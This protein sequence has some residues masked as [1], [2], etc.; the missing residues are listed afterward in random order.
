MAKKTTE[1]EPCAEVRCPIYEMM[2]YL[3]GKDT[4]GSKVLEHLSNARTEVLL[5]IRELI[6][7]RI[8]ELQKKKPESGGKSKRIKVTEKS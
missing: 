3:C 6:D 7:A 8:E 2:Q 5:G 1:Q 4:V